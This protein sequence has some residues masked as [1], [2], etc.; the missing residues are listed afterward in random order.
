MGGMLQGDFGTFGM[1]W[2]ILNFIFVI[3]LSAGIVILVIW[4]RRRLAATKQ[5]VEPSSEKEKGQPS[6]RDVLRIRYARGEISRKEYR[7]M[8]S[9]LG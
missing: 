3:G 6:P 9:D 7:E 4:L 2:I 8:L 1:L 5:D